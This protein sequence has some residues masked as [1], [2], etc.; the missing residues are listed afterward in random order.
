M[1]RILIVSIMLLALG[2]YATAA[3]YPTSVIAENFGA[4]W[5]AA[6]GFAVEGLN[7]LGAQVP[8]H[9]LSIVRLLTESGPD[10]SSPDIDARF[11]YYEVLGFPAV[12]FNGKIRIDGSGEG[13]AD[14]SRYLEALNQLR[15][16]AS[17][18]KLDITSF[19]ANSGTIS[20][21]AELLHPELEFLD[22]SVYF[23]L[24]E[25]DVSAGLNHVVRDIKSQRMDISY[26]GSSFS[27]N[28]TFAISYSWNLA[29]LWA[30][31]FVQAEN[32][33]ILQSASTL[34]LPQ[35]RMQAAVPFE[36]I[37]YGEANTQYYSPAFYIYNLGAAD[38]FTRQIEVVSAPDDWY[39]N[40]C[41]VEGNCYP[42]SFPIPTTL[43]TGEYEAL[44]LN[45]LV[46]SAGT[47]VFNFVISSDNLGEYKI[48]F[49]Y[50]VGNS[51]SDL[52]SPAFTAQIKAYPNPFSQS[53]SF[54]L[55]SDKAL[56][57]TSIA[58]YNLKGQLQKELALEGLK[59]GTTK[60]ELDLGDLP[61]GV[62]LYK[63]QGSTSGGKIL[64]IK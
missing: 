39:F 58:I 36:R 15:Y 37:I 46:G 62:Y 52:L 51:N 47:A 14:G 6:C 63:L 59:A 45:I 21:S 25:D 24:V 41:D 16:S 11:N 19:D 35:Y 20:L 49:E 8:A 33:A 50:H 48:P 57:A 18:L 55:Q 40:Y 54:E 64:K 1:K 3:F 13:I 10:Y 60:L 27:L 7:T 56:P 4:E 23:Y 29:K 53:L 26:T 43:G 9:E 32:G 28:E 38:T 44:D 5:C 30:V 12:I 17:P 31:A 61:G 34:A 22:S 42:G 2:L